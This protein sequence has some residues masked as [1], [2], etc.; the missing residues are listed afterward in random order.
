MILFLSFSVTH[1]FLYFSL[2]VQAKKR[3]GWEHVRLR[4]VHAQVL[5]TSHMPKM[6]EPRPEVGYVTPRHEREGRAPMSK[7]EQLRSSGFPQKYYPDPAPK[8]PP[9]PPPPPPTSTAEQQRSSVFGTPRSYDVPAGK[10]SSSSARLSSPMSRALQNASS[11]FG[12]QP[13][14]HA[15]PKA[16]REQTRIPTSTAEQNASSVFGSPRRYQAPKSQDASTDKQHPAG[17]GARMT[18]AQQNASS[19]FG[20]PRYTSPPPQLPRPKSSPANSKAAQNA[21]S[22]FCTPR[23]TSPPP[24]PARKP[25]TIATDSVAQNASTVFGTPRRPTP[26]PLVAA[27][28]TAGGGAQKHFGEGQWMAPTPRPASEGAPKSTAVQQQSHSL[29]GT[30]YPL[31]APR[32]KPRHKAQSHTRGVTSHTAR[33]RVCCTLP[34]AC[35]CD[36]WLFLYAGLQLCQALHCLQLC[37]HPLAVIVYW[38]AL[39]K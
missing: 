19:V 22:A 6:R 3:T 31:P 28:S 9:P 13:M 12:D 30:V 24:Q 26:E 18:H 29:P 5:Y 25:P 2:C 39:C 34:S 37:P 35:V 1:R 32:A 11:V 8:P 36:I 21:S 27:H 20:S 7:Q 10:S 4:V 23:Y 38:R 33:G 17:K 15:P 14:Y 16:P